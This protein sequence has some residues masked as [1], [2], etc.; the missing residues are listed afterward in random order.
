[1]LIN[2][3]KLPNI[4]KERKEDIAMFN[5]FGNRISTGYEDIDGN[6]VKIPIGKLDNANLICIENKFAEKQGMLRLM[7]KDRLI[8]KII[9]YITGSRAGYVYIESKYLYGLLS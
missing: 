6:Y 2:V 8:R 1:M 5:K 3:L 4:L 7:T 9:V